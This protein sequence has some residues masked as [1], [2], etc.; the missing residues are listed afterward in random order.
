MS[1]IQSA[2]SGTSASVGHACKWVSRT[3]W[4]G[5][6]AACIL[7]LSAWPSFAQS[8]TIAPPPFLTAFSNAGAII[9]N[10]CV[11]TYS[12]GTTTP[13][14]TYA[15]TVGTQNS[16][17]IRS[18]S[19]GRFTAYLI[20]GSG[21]KFQFESACTPPAHGT[22]LRTADNIAG[23]AAASS[24][25]DITGTAGVA[26]S[27]GQAVYLSDGSGG[28]IA[29]QWYLADAT[30]TYSSTTLWVGIAPSAIASGS[31][32]T[33]RLAGSVTG[34]SGLTVGA[35]YWIAG[36]PGALTTTAPANV[37]QVGQADTTSS[38]VLTANPYPTP[39][40]PAPYQPITTYTAT[41]ANVQ[42]TIVET[43]IVSFVVPASTWADGDPIF[44]QLVS[45]DKNN[46]GGAL[47]V[48]AKVNVGAG[49]QVPLVTT[50]SENDSATEFSTNRSFVLVR[51]GSTVNVFN[52]ALGNLWTTAFGSGSG[53]S[54]GTSTPTNFTSSI[55][56]S[57]KV[58]LSGADA[59][60]YLKPQSARV[61]KQGI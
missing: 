5:I 34:L 32:G 59:T 14:A 53:F 45:L 10:A 23:S 11:W 58:T 18:D 27:A 26:I 15:D 17:P 56:V 40:T 29:G 6:V 49:A 60:F 12:A 39:A 41:L 25:T 33:I 52:P 1:S 8:Y 2:Q 55:T 20:A 42:N 28:K 22:I 48:T 19:A 4:S 3:Y 24:T 57:L 43:T 13:V 21:Y 37:R 47:T 61:W 35:V 46:S 54:L 31:S 51:N 30:N 7:L 38:L 36:T 50:V 16:N 9:N 44:V